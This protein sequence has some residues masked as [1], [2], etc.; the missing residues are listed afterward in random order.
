MEYRYHSIDPA[1]LG[2]CAWLLKHRLYQ[3]WREGNMCEDYLPL[4][5]IKGKPGAGKSTLMKLAIDDLRAHDQKIDINKIRL[6]I[7]AF[8]FNARGTDLE[9]LPQGCY[10]ALIH[11]LLEKHLLPL[12]QEPLV[13]FQRKEAIIASGWK[14][15][16]SELRV[17]FRRALQLA[18]LNSSVVIYVDAL[19]E[20]DASQIRPLV[21]FLVAE[22]D[23][24]RKTG[25]PF[26][27]C[28][29]SRHYPNIVIPNCHII[30]AEAH[31]SSDIKSYV[32]ANVTTE[33]IG[34][35]LVQRIADDASGIFLW[36]KL[37][38]SR[39]REAIEDGEPEATLED[40]LKSTPQDLEDIFHNLWTSLKPAEIKESRTLLLF[41][42]FAKQPVSVSQLSL[43]LAYQ[44]PYQ[45]MMDYLHSKKFMTSLQMEKSITKS[46]RGLLEITR[47][48]GLFGGL[49]A[50]QFIH[51]TVREYFLDNPSQLSPGTS[52]TEDLRGLAN[53][54]IAKACFNFTI[55]AYPRTFTDQRKLG[56]AHHPLAR[57]VGKHAFAHASEAERR[58][59][60]QTYILAAMRMN[61]PNVHQWR[62]L[63]EEF[64]KIK[65]LFPT[66]ISLCAKYNIHS[67]LEA[68]PSLSEASVEEHKDLEEALS[69][70]HLD[71]DDDTK[72]IDESTKT[73]TTTME[74]LMKKGLNVSLQ[75]SWVKK[76]AE[77]Q[78]SMQST[79]TPSPPYGTKEFNEL[80]TSKAE[81]PESVRLA[82]NL[83]L[84][85]NQ[86]WQR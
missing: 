16:E 49:N 22:M 48:V 71:D 41:V 47:N 72:M 24:A 77:I 28:V 60:P 4:I 6:S 45:S 23:F 50:V 17:M 31:N 42:L 14:W 65:G 12:D 64:P 1:F 38:L 56:Y 8:F 68:L 61:S 27:L 25:T 51:G 84:A 83:E 70:N 54:L 15:T 63:L 55:T 34:S 67:A 11:Q 10:R 5:W 9:T 7:N 76:Q 85:G 52:E 44:T 66:V 18:S 59:R 43:L 78:A 26:R 79:Y 29:S 36:T 73:K 86:I 20:C 35:G 39:M 75:V 58:G 80:Q 3:I 19:D 46:A 82:L 2:T 13:T 81:L 62:K 30:V 21:D 40:I 32:N 37:V 33:L 53:D 57:Y 74:T 69:C